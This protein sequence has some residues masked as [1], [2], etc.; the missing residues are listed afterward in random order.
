MIE[1]E[2][3][4]LELARKIEAEG[5]GFMLALAIAESTITTRELA[6]RLDALESHPLVAA[7]L[8][9]RR[10]PLRAM[11]ADQAAAHAR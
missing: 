2:D 1:H 11:S 7:A 8:R 6:A 5:Y 4:V 3:L 10:V 9:R